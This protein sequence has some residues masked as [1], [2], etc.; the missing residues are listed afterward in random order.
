MSS[1]SELRAKIS[2]FGGLRIV[3]VFL[4]VVFTAMMFDPFGLDRCDAFTEEE[5]QD[6]EAMLQKESRDVKHE[7]AENDNGMMF[8]VYLKLLNEKI[9]GITWQCVNRD[10]YITRVIGTVDGSTAKIEIYVYPDDFSLSV[11]FVGVG[12]IHSRTIVT[13]RALLPIVREW[14]RTITPVVV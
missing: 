6:C 14:I 7:K 13:Y 1:E 5:S 9:D 8:L 10:G 4:N 12:D 2:T 3:A 11:S